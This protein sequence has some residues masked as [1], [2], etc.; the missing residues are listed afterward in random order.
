MY[1]SQ[2]LRFAIER[3]EQADA[4]NTLDN[5]LVKNRTNNRKIH[6]FVV[7]YGAQDKRLEA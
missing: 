5:I 3:Q 6:F 2:S 7:E 1:A 4:I